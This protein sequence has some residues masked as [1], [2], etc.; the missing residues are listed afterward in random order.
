MVLGHFD[1]I[2]AIER[3][4]GLGAGL[5]QTEAGGRKLDIQERSDPLGQIVRSC[6][7]E[8]VFQ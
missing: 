4:V 7:F 6:R 8:A 3:D 5:D 2:A 1:T